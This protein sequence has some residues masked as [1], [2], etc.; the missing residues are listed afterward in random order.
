M[1]I[2]L[3][4][5]LVAL[6]KDMVKDCD[7]LCDLMQTDK[8]IFKT[9]N[10]EEIMASNNKKSILMNQISA[11][12]NEVNALPTSDP[13]NDFIQNLELAAVSAAPASQKELLEILDQ[14]KH[15]LPLCN[16]H[17]NLN[18]RIVAS[19]LNTMAKLWEKL[20]NLKEN[21]FLYD[22]KGNTAR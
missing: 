9:H 15:S 20:S 13:K 12:A 6:L 16:E 7:D 1:Q 18:S 17:A 4:A 10:P 14:L 22:N 5:S 21:N 19:T 2:T 8:E 3:K 11:V